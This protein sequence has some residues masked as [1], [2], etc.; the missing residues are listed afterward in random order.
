[1]PETLLPIQKALDHLL[2]GV[3]NLEAGIAWV[4]EKT[5]VKAMPGGRHPGLGTHNALLSLGPRQY[6]EIIAPDPTQTTLAPQF[7]F[8]QLATSPRLL[9]WAAATSDIHA[10]AT[11][12]HAAGFELSGP[13]AGARTR[14]D[15]QTLHWQTL[16]IKNDLSLQIPFFIAW[17][18]AARHP[19]QD[20]PVGCTLQAFAMEHPQPEKLRA[21]LMQ[22]GLDATV[23]RGPEARLRAFIASPQGT[24][25]LA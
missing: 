20:S 13:H 23:Q 14:P 10:V 7:A 11:Q 17:D 18:T 9:T 3:P 16:F 4:E 25:E 6:L 21:A 8:L 24:I 15:G 12:A 2:L 22:L 19:A 5:G 1:M